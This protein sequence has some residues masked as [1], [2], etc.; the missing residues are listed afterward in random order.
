MH[1]FQIILRRINVH[2]MCVQGWNRHRMGKLACLPIHESCAF[3]DGYAMPLI[4]L[5]TLNLRVFP[6]TLVE[7]FPFVDNGESQ[8]SVGMEER[9]YN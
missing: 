5:L 3:V 8:N 6:L 7:R 1:M 4:S 2:T 9:L